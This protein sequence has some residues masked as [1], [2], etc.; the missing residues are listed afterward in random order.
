ME[1]YSYPD[2]GDSSPRSREIDF[3]NP[4]PW[5]DQQQPPINYKPKFMCSYGGKIQPR[6]HDNHLSYVA[7]DTK[8]LAVDR[9]IKFST[10]LSKLSSLSSFPSDE[11]TFKYQLPGEELDALI[12]VTNDDDLDHLMNEYDRLYRTSSTPS[13]MRLFLFHN[14]TSQPQQRFIQ[15]IESGSIPVPVQVQVPVQ[16]DPMKPSTNVDFLFGLENKGVAVAPPQPPPVV[17][18]FLD[19]VAEPVAALP[20]YQQRGAVVGS[21]PNLNHPF[22]VQRQLQQELQRMRIAENDQAAYRRKSSEDNRN[23][24]GNYP[25]GEYYVQKQPEKFPVSNFQANAPN[26]AGYWP[27][28]H[29]SGEFY[30]PAMSNASGGGE[31]PVYMIPAPGTFY[32]APMMRPPSAPQVTQGYYTVQRMGSDGYRDAPV[33]GSVQPPKAAFST[34]SPSNLAPAQPVKGPSYTEGYGVVRP[35][36]ISDNTGAYAQM[37][38][39]SVSGRQVYY[40]AP[41]GVV[42]APPYQGMAPPA[43]T[44]RVTVGQ[45]GKLI[46]KLSQGSV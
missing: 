44:D 30:P 18:K 7:G 22:E 39:D 13:R 28:K 4:P 2:S 33:Y 35:G 10:F 21:D 19:P 37:A 40:N 17:E 42:Q 34:A 5:D 8:I 43:T 26:Q 11:L 25:S 36:G 41:G 23:L 45:D 1:N 32:H 46:N 12:S 16:P 3:D 9:H 27:E 15:T 29:G 38:Y 14:I 24:V 31:Q 6:S 20:E